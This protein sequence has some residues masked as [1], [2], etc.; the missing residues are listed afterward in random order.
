MDNLWRQSLQST[1]ITILKDTLFQQKLCANDYVLGQNHLPNNSNFKICTLIIGA[2]HTE[3]TWGLQITDIYILQHW[4]FYYF[5][6]RGNKKNKIWCQISGKVTSEFKNK[7]VS[8]WGE[9]MRK[10]GCHFMR[11]CEGERWSRL[12][13]HLST[14]KLSLHFILSGRLL[15]ICIVFAAGQKTNL[16]CADFR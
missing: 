15:L 14:N 9:R 2:W 6:Q 3:W 1:I 11:P 4:R 16:L 10:K 5:N 7:C 13:V 8:M 12:C